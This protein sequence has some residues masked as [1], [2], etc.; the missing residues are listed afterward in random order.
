MILC[1]SGS[2]PQQQR[3]SSY[4]EATEDRSSYAEASTFVE[5]TV[6]R[7]VDRTEDR[8][9]GGRHLIAAKPETN[10]VGI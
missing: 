8:E 4:A 6:D 5:T 7:T 10:R 1:V 2:R 3:A 9:V